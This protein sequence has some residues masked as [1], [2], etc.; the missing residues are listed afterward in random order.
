MAQIFL[1]YSRKDQRPMIAV[2]TALTE[3]G[4]TVW[5]DE[6]LEPGTPVWQRKVEVEIEAASWMVVLLS[7]AAK[8][9]DWVRS[10]IGR[11][12]IVGINIVPLIV[13]GEN[14]R[15][16]LPLGLENTNWIDIRSHK[17]KG[18]DRLVK[19]L[20]PDVVPMIVKE[21]DPDDSL[22]PGSENANRVDTRR[23]KRAGDLP[24]PVETVT[25]PTRGSD[26][27]IGSTYVSAAAEE[28]PVDDRYDWRDVGRVLAYYSRVD[29]VG[30]ELSGSIQLGDL[31]FFGHGSSGLLQRVESIEKNRKRV[32]KAAAGEQV[33]INVGAAVKLGSMVRK[34]VN[35]DRAL[36][37]GTVSHFY[38]NL[39]VISVHLEDPLAPGDRIEIRGPE[40][41]FVQTVRSIEIDRR[42]V[43]AARAGQ[44]IGL[45]TVLPA[46]EGDRV[47]RFM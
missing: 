35:A 6:K 42:P 11:A 40:T 31:L 7:P 47:Y 13:D 41:R 37:V 19:T 2:K 16:F 21:T 33:G 23:H 24:R 25:P 38:S 10:E 3:A 26:V 15:D 44:H 12:R 34:A 32:E 17:R 28:G 18:L 36:Y 1:S 9:S 43:T 20:T 30:V 5:T 27:A 45:A 4:L 8:D 39:S 46:R 14:P 29:A 22:P